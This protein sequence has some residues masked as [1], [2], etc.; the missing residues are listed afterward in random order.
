[1][2]E[3]LASSLLDLDRGLAAALPDG[4]R[5][6]AR[7]ALRAR[8][9]TLERGA[10]DAIGDYGDRA[11]WMGLL[12]TDGFLSRRTT[13]GEETV[14]EIV[15]PGDLLR[16]WD[17]DAEYPVVDGISTTRQ[18][19]AAM[20][21]AIIDEDLATRI[22]AWP[23]LTVAILARI[24]RRDRWLALRLLVSQLPGLELR[25]LY[26]LWHIAERWGEAGEG[27][28]RIPAPLT[29][30]HIGELIGA[31]RPSVSNAVSALREKGV[32]RVPGLGWEIPLDAPATI[33]VMLAAG[34]VT[35]SSGR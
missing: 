14:G 18:V 1:M 24:G 11:S 23:Q 7:A 27:V 29:H 22:A 20:T 26:L 25:V 21:I 4:Q 5:E 35:S 15:G 12:V 6:R 32:K 33:E 3:T 31:Q 8:T 34:A 13:C 9:R 17:H 28:L 30:E 19:L 16:P 2:T 10:W